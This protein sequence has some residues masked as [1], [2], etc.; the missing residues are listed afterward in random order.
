MAH[1]VERGEKMTHSVCQ[2]S[3]VIFYS[4]E[5]AEMYARGLDREESVLSMWILVMYEF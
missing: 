1:V 3:K 4:E 5:A 2:G